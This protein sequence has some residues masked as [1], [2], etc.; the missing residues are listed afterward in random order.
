VQTAIALMGLPSQGFAD[1]C[2][3]SASRGNGFYTGVNGHFHQL[4]PQ[5]TDQDFTGFSDRPGRQ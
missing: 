1:D 2:E 5:R 4:P 3:A